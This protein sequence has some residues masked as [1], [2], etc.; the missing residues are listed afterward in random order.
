MA[1]AF[2]LGELAGRVGGRVIG[3]ARRE[4]RGVAPLDR[5]GP[6]ELSFLTNPR[7]RAA[8][9]S[10]RAA[11]VLVGPGVTLAGQ[12]LLEAP[13][14]YLALAE[15]LEALHPEPPARPGISPDARVDRSATLGRDVA[16][17]AF[18]VIGERATLGDEVVVGA[19]AVVGAGSR[20]G[21]RTVLYPR[22]V[23]YDRTQVGRDCRIHSGVV[24]GADGFGFA[25]SG[26]RHRKVPQLG[27]VVIQDDVEIGSNTTIDRGALGDTVIGR[28]TKIDDLVMVAHGVQVGPDCLLVAQSGLAGSTRLGARVT[29]AGQSGA[30]GHLAIGDDVT[31]AAK[32]A[33]FADVP[34]G[35]V[36]AGTP[37][38]GIRDWRRTQAAAKRLPQLLNEVR[39]L[40]ERLERLEADLSRKE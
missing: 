9:E 39:R 18:A 29:V 2:R 16:V 26:G 31:I 1:P 40:R 35:S 33:V 23:L 24:L 36:V 32:T 11:A 3:D 37:A 19:G 22:V 34:A 27:R 13:E 6:D 8:A 15:I 14:P 38:V 7:Y 20:I 5:A 30:A 17:G 28:G 21:D 10:T 4:V 12:T 25:T